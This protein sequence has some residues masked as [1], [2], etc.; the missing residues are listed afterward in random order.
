[1]ELFI[2]LIRS[3]RRLVFG[4]VVASVLS[5]ALGAALI[6]VV[7]RALSEGGGRGLIMGAFVAIAVGKVLTACA[8]NLMLVRFAQDTVLRLCRNL[9]DKVL[10][11]PFP[12]LEM[13]GAPR[14]LTTLTEDVAILTAAVLAIPSI[15]TN[16]AI[17]VGSAAYLAW[18][19][20]QLFLLSAVVVGIGVAGYR[21]LALRA[22]APLKA[23]RDGR[24]R[25]FGDFRTLIDGIKELKQHRGRREEFM[26]EELD[27]TMNHLREQNVAAVRKH[28]YADAWNQFLFLG[29]IGVLL[30]AAPYV[31]SLDASTLTAFVFASLYM[32]T[33][34]WTILAAVPTF[35][36]GRISLEKIQEL[37]D[38]LGQAEVAP[39]ARE[40]GAAAREVSIEFKGATY[41][42]LS[43]EKDESGFTLGPFDLTLSSGEVVFITGGNGSGKS[44]LVKLLTGLYVPSAGA[45]RLNGRL[46]DDA[47]RESYRQCFSV[48]FADFHL[49]GKLF[50]LDTHQRE[51]EIQRYLTVLH[52]Q[53]KVSVREGRFSSTALS[54]GQRKRLA[55]LT[56]YLEDR[57][58]YVFDEWAADQDPTYKDI[59]YTR[60]LPELKARGKC[61]VVIT[62]D[63]RYFSRGDRVLKLEAG[64]VTE[65]PSVGSALTRSAL[66][67]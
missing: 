56:A 12:K 32:M 26:R 39:V 61:V 9:C 16:L 63:D 64:Q 45:I 57:P 53:D 58:I 46:L 44:T 4:T 60:L 21:I 50:G 5:G 1:M 18:I 25:L 2:F 29:L 43:P 17:I 8:S 41:E 7:N 23:A 14:I 27:V 35:M 67:Q 15:A 42:Y 31:R 19:S 28:T 65:L 66:A 38:T 11:A 48:V 33:P 34:V 55:L 54:S 24:D 40:E 10:A 13:L 22:F 36:R 51:A 52:M 3:A 6:A 47:G 62:H 37:G 20:W 49:F 59:F 30:F